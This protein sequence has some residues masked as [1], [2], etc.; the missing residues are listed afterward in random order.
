MRARTGV[1]TL[2]ESARLTGA[3]AALVFTFLGACADDDAELAN[4]ESNEEAASNDMNCDGGVDCLTD[5][6][7]PDAGKLD[8]SM[9]GA[10]GTECGPIVCSGNQACLPPAVEYVMSMNFNDTRATYRCVDCAPNER[11][12][13]SWICGGEGPDAD[14]DGI[15]GDPMKRTLAAPFDCDDANP[16]VYEGQKETCE[17]EGIDNDCD[18]T[19]VVYQGTDD[20]LN[21][22]EYF[23]RDG[24]NYLDRR[25][26][27]WSPSANAFIY[28]DAQGNPT[29]RGEFDCD[30]SKVERSPDNEEICDG[31]D[32]DCDLAYDE[33]E[34][35]EE[36]G[37]Q[38]KYCIDRDGDG[39]YAENDYEYACP[40]PR[41]LLYRECSTIA[42]YD[43]NDADV[44]DFPGANERCDLLDN[45]CNEK[46]DRQPDEPPMVDEGTFYGALLSCNLDEGKLEYSDC[47]ANTQWC[48]RRTTANGCETDISSLGHCNGCK[49]T[50]CTH[51]CSLEKNLEGCEEVRQLAVGVDFSC[52]STAVVG[53]DGEL[54]AGVSC[55]GRGA[56]GRLGNG[57]EVNSR[58]PVAVGG[59][60]DVTSVCVGFAHACAIT[61]AGDEA[62]CWGRN[63]EGQLSQSPD[64]IPTSPVPLQV[65]GGDVDSGS[66]LKG[67]RAIACGGRFACALLGSRVVCWGAADRA[68]LGNPTVQGT[69]SYPVYVNRITDTI[70]GQLPAPVADASQVT[71]GSG[72]GCLLTEGGDVECWG[73]NAFGQLG[74][75]SDTLSFADTTALVAGLPA[76]VSKV[77]AGD[78]HSCALASKRV[79]CWGANEYGQ[80]G[81]AASASEAT[82]AEVAAAPDAVDLFAGHGVTCI[83]TAEKSLY[84][85]GRKL[86]DATPSASDP[87]TD[88]PYEI[89]GVPN[90][91]T[92]ALGVHA[93][94]RSGDEVRCWGLNSF[95]Q[96]GNGSTS[97]ERTPP[98]GLRER[99]K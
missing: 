9:E 51:A 6:G 99:S 31:E 79:Y 62:Y 21:E 25:C 89:A 17:R 71:L 81:R 66:T 64:E 52:G 11:G 67:V 38:V 83:I 42:K 23:N 13:L 53:Q 45:D 22:L 96:L 5:T 8:A 39:F 46:V 44:R 92:V 3:I 4:A 58:V 48:D 14:G 35:R 43:C 76:G 40:G 54:P 59:L 29:P 77:A 26:R 74:A 50:T 16:Q 18:P 24:D 98:V 56:E 27:N 60:L 7:V 32:N 1:L 80:L 95:G 61:G 10:E 57:A 33:D 37:L 2:S 41:S 34:E 49:P 85:W 55:W 75:A 68:Q 63:K 15:D 47:P 78:R 84:C 72:H 87:S 28:A 69:Y 82:P 65:V 88:T 94:A 70:F 90:V 30:D 12:E 20:G 91:D 36:G 86:E 19:T 73:D 93:C 97:V